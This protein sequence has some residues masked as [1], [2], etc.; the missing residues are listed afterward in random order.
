MLAFWKSIEQVLAQKPSARG[1]IYFRR[2]MNQL[3]PRYTAAT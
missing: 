1:A 2:F 3:N